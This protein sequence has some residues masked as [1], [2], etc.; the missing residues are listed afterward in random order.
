MRT[1]IPIPEQLALQPSAQVKRRPGEW[2]LLTDLGRQLGPWQLERA[3]RVGPAKVPGL[4]EGFRFHDL[5]HYLA[6]L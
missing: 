2:L 5:R 6:S 4:P 1:P 3:V